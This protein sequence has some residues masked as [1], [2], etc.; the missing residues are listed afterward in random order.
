MLHIYGKEAVMM[1]SAYLP[2]SESR[3]LNN[4]CTCP[5]FEPFGEKT[6]IMDIT[7][8]IDPDQHRYAS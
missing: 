6:N 8:I 4:G 1:V 3:C 5:I 2:Y 7:E